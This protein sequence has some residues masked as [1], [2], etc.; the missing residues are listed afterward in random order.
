MAQHGRGPLSSWQGWLGLQEM[1]RGQ[2]QDPWGPCSLT[3]IPHQVK[4]HR[5]GSATGSHK[6]VLFSLG[7]G[8]Y[9][10]SCGIEGHGLCARSLG[11]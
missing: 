5:T 7:W 4:A 2:G 10:G 11:F 1:Q 9:P 3:A 6:V 8:I